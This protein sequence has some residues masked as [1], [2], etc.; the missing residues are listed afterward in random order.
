MMGVCEAVAFILRTHALATQC[1][2][3]LRNGCEV[4]MTTH[5]MTRMLWPNCCRLASQVDNG[6][7]NFWAINKRSH[8]I[9]KSF[10]LCGGLPKRAS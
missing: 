2:P 9:A 4:D 7:G 5:L 6:M 1:L 10:K 8:D 3:S